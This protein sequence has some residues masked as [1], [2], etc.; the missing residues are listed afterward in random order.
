MRFW[1]PIKMG[2]LVI[3]ERQTHCSH[4][5]R[6]VNLLN[7]IRYLND[8]LYIKIFRTFKVFKGL[9]I[10]STILWVTTPYSLVLGN[11]HF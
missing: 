9:N 1:Y 5:T 4:D 6:Y 7:I 2:D 11:Q 10:H 3:M 8:V